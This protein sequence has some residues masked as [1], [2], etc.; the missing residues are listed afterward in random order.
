MNSETENQILNELRGQTVLLKKAMRANTVAII[1]LG[2]FILFF[3]ISISLRSRL[4]ANSNPTPQSFDSWRVANDLSDRG[5]YKESADMIQRL[6]NKHPDYYYGYALMGSLQL[7]LGNLQD[8]EAN[9]AKAY[10]LLP[11]EDNEKNLVAI[12]KALEK[13]KTSANKVSEAIAPQGGA[14]SQR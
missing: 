3:F 5:N 10:D 8:A 2:I 7:E 9:Y 4:H 11:T 12:R 1:M 13:K 14:Q 6:I